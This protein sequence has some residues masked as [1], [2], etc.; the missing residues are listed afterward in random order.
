M[1]ITILRILLLVA[2][3]GYFWTLIVFGVG[4]WIVAHPTTENLRR[5]L[6]WN[7]ANPTIW[8]LSAR[9]RLLSLNPGELREA[10]EAYPQSLARNPWDP[11]AWE[12]LASIYSRLGDEQKEEAAWRG[13]V[14]TTPHSPY[15]AWGLANFLLQ[16]GRIEE[17][18]P[19]FR[20]AATYDP[21]LRAS[22]FELAWKLLADPQ[23]IFKELVPADTAARIEY[24]NFLIWK[25]G[26]LREAY[27]VWQEILT[28]GV[29]HTVTLGQSY[30]EVLAAAGLGAEASQVW[31]E[32][33]GRTDRPGKT[34]SGEQITN[35]DFEWPLRN[36]GLDWRMG[37]A[38]GYRISLDNF[39]YQEGTRSLRV[40]FDGTTNPE[41][42]AV[43]QWVPVE[44]GRNY[45]FRAHLR[46]DNLSTDNGIFLSVA[47][48]RAPPAESWEHLT[49]TRV[50]SS[51]WTEE[52][53]DLQTGSDT[54]VVLIQLRRRR[55]T[56]LNNL[57]QGTV[58]IDNLSLRIRTP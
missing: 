47:T 39:V 19:L 16:G 38:P 2:A 14:L 26:L 21:A 29:E 35:G 32:I 52:M 57:L 58:W 13:G 22:L 56:K 37:P 27:P 54:R 53:I 36:A 15:A 4:A 8:R 6:R 49:E 48:Q 5:G 10:A 11:L 20:T 50:G 17:A 33:L 40:D 18:L 23:R 9:S 1:R 34:S 41:F 25:K 28:S 31:R 45:Q 24:M 3:L 51:P 55:S 12:G 44:P 30:V 46:T 7:S 42:A 43:Q